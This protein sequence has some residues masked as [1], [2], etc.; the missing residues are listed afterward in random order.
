MQKILNC[1]IYILKYVLVGIIIM[2]TMAIIQEKGLIYDDDLAFIFV[3][4]VSTVVFTIMM[5]L[6]KKNVKEYLR[7]NVLNNKSVLSLI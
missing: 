1:I 7:F 3:N 4:L 2:I 6:E 5:K